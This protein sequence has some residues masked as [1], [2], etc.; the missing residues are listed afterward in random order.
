MSQLDLAIFAL[1]RELKKA[2]IDDPCP[3][4]SYETGIAIL[5]AAAKVTSSDKIAAE[6]G[7][8]T[9]SVRILIRALPDAP[10]TDEPAKEG[11]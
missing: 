1:K 7:I 4:C 8:A 2:V 10:Q 11:K 3:I 5:Q 6:D 9:M